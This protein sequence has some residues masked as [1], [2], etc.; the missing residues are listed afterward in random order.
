MPLKDWSAAV[1]S[2]LRYNKLS[3]IKTKMQ[4]VDHWDVHIK[5][6]F[7]I[8]YAIP[9]NANFIKGYFFSICLVNQWSI[10][11]LQFLRPFLWWVKF[12][13]NKIKQHP[14]LSCE[15]TFL[16]S[17]FI[18][19]LTQSHP[20]QSLKILS[21]FTTGPWRHSEKCTKRERKVVEKNTLIDFPIMT[22]NSIFI[23][24]L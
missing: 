20:Q 22:W 2:R 19:L 8:L 9:Q 21:T 3:T 5:C 10:N 6:D 17:S 24:C 7:W 1:I 15:N 11:H 18:N 14:L 16:M 13:R 4:K 12:V 23:D